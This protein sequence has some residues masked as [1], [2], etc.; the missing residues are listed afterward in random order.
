[1]N[2]EE[3]IQKIEDALEGIPSGSI[4]Q[5]VNY[6]NIENWSSMHA[7]MLMALIDSEYGVLLSGE[8]MAQC[9]TINDLFD[10]VVLKMT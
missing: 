7:L 8:E 4:Q 10:V 9:E 1:M 2:I 3:F 5:G 6:R